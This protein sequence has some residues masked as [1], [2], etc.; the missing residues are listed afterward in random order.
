MQT[1]VYSDDAIESFEFY[2]FQPYASTTLN[3][4]DEI[5]IPIPDQNIYPYL[6]LSYLNIEGKLLNNET[7]SATLSFINNGVAFLFD[8][9]R[10]EGNGTSIDFTRNVGITSLLKGYCS[11][12][13]S[14]TKR[15]QNAGW[16]HSENPNIVDKTTGNFNVCIPLKM[17]MGFFEDFRRILLRVRLELILI[18]SNS[19]VNATV[20]NDATEEPVIRL[21]KITWKVPIVT[22]SDPA[23]LFLLNQ[24]N[25]NKFLNVS[26]RS[27]ELQEYP[28]VPSTT[29]HTWTV[30]TSGQLEKPRFIIF[31]FQTNRKNVKSRNMSLFDHCQLTNLK[32]HL[33]S[34]MYPYGDLKL[35]FTTKS[36]AFLYEMYALFQ[37]SYYSVPQQP[38]LT[39]NDFFNHNGGF[40]VVDCSCQNE[41]L[42]SGIVI[43]KL[44]FDTS[45]AIPDKTSAYCLILHDRLVTYNPLSGEVV[46][47]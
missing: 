22:V 27:W 37:D 14:E 25:T 3:K 6:H 39:P 41:M 45:E 36:Y 42:K 40:V 23:K 46:A 5:R 10:L 13:E 43:L 17:L 34:K 28:L 47:S 35:N 26:F 2:D 24:I 12:S 11:F 18:R 15:L 32:V 1:A 44:E 38:C 30:K 8:S 19:D 4:S 16:S 33:N 9:I 31:G 21:N 20:T 7:P 29:K